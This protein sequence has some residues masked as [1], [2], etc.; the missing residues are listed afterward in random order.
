[1]KALFFS[2]LF[3]FGALKVSAQYIFTNLYTKDGLSSKEISS[4]FQDSDGFIWFGTANGLNRYDGTSFNVFN[5]ANHNFPGESENI[6]SIKEYG[7]AQLWIGTA[8]GLVKYDKLHSRFSNIPLPVKNGR[9]P[10]VSVLITDAQ[11]RLWILSTSGIFIVR[12]SVPVPVTDLYPSATPLNNLDL[13]GFASAYDPGR[14]GMWIGTNKGLHF[15][16]FATKST[17]SKENNPHGWKLFN[18]QSYMQSIVLDKAGNMYISNQRYLLEYFNFTTNH[19]DSTSAI[20]ADGKKWTLGGG[21][22]RMYIDSKQRLWLSSW[23]H[24]CFVRS[25]DGHYDVLPYQSTEPFKMSYGFFHD[26]CEDKE[27][28]LWLA[29]LNG[30]HKLISN[31]YLSDIRDIIPSEEDAHRIKSANQLEAPT[32]VFAKIGSRQWLIGKDDGLF[33]WNEDSGKPVRYLPDSKTAH[34]NRIFEINHINNQWWIGTGYGIKI[35]DIATKSFRDFTAYPKGVNGKNSVLWIRQDRNGFIWFTTW[36]DALFRYDP[37]TNQTTYFR[38]LDGDTSDHTGKNFLCY[39]EDHRGKI[40][41]DYAAD[42]LR[43]FDPATGKFH[44]PAPGKLHTPGLI[45][46]GLLEDHDKNIW[47]ST[48]QKGLLK[49]NIEGACLDS[50]T[51]ADGLSMMNVTNIFEDSYGRIW[52]STAEGIHYL[53]KGSHKIH[54]LGLDIGSSLYDSWSFFVQEGDKLYTSMLHK[55]VVIDLSKVGSMASVSAPLISKISV[56]ENEIPFNIL[57]PEITLDYDQNFFVIEFSSLDHQQLSS[58][59][60]AYKLEGFD[61]DWVYSGNRKTASYTNVPGGKYKFLL[62]TA[63][64]NGTW[65][66]KVTVI[67][68]Q[69]RYPFWRRWWFVAIL[70]LL[71]VLAGWW[72]YNRR[73]KFKQKQ[74]LDRTIDYFANSVYGENSVTE[75][76]WDIARNCI[77]QLN[78]EDCI[79]YLFE[80]DKKRLV[81]KAAYGAKNPKGHEIINPIEIEPGKGIVGTVAAT[82]KALLIEDT[83]NDSRYIVDDQPRRSELAVPIMHD[84]E[85]IGVI[86][87]ENSKKNYFTHDHLK[88]LSTIASISANKIAEARAEELGRQNEVK[89]LEIN[90]MLAESQLMALRAQMNPHFVF[91]CL[92]SIQECIVTQKYGEAS[93]YLNK[94]SKLFRMVLNNSGETLVTIDDEKEV[95]EL[96]LE[97]EVM[98]FEKSFSYRIRVDET[99]ETDEILVPSMLLQP[100]VENALWHGLMHKEGERNLVVQFKRVSD[101]IFQCIIDDNGVG[102]ERSFE[103]KQQQSKAKHHVSKGMRISKDRLNLLQLQNQHATIEIIDKHDEHGNATGTTVLI[104]LSTYLK[105]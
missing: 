14:K 71:I 35:F 49:C 104:E 26:A 53:E 92:N 48:N 1:M 60:Y 13:V 5:L 95:L 32:N 80:D 62:K 11:K 103:L 78:F 37:R 76:C 21:I 99:L 98:R 41:L 72:V 8:A 28:N 82:G 18:D 16:D 89:L 34:G 74:K 81:Q 50:F 56:F 20:D 12:D 51:T 75:I 94:F 93:K 7:K 88:A 96:Y 105:A 39:L 40:W 27:G 43:I 10:R 79:V 25:P 54:K 36:V 17:W 67:N 57:K 69:V 23:L 70:I 97:L 2:I 6:T 87:S 46:N 91:N 100:Y 90:R 68:I 22:H 77:S 30:T 47:V 31:S 9:E 83:L 52:M 38:N 63:E 55:M 101:E 19:V 85:V 15:I 42:G 61:K 65:S 29:G 33:L 45:V 84:N 66:N 4:V 44:K 58:I 86:D 102:R 24:V 64:A 3:F 59:N 73:W